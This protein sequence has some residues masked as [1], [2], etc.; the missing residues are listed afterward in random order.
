MFLFA[1]SL[2]G[3]VELALPDKWLNA[4]NRKSTSSRGLTGII[5]MALTFTLTSFTCTV[6][7]IGTVMV[8]AL[9][10]NAGWAL[11]GVISFAVV[12]SLPFFSAGTI[13]FLAAVTSPKRKL[14]EFR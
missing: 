7:F 5:L 6:P 11:L 8:A 3:V 14:D 2:F 13:P 12:F 1:L 9:Q 4:I 10:G